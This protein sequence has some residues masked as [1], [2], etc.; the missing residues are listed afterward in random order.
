MNP[1][2]CLSRVNCTNQFVEG[3]FR[4]INEFQLI[5]E[6]EMVELAVHY[7]SGPSGLKALRHHHQG[8]PTSQKRDKRLLVPPTE[9]HTQPASLVS[10]LPEATQA[11][12]A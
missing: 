6:E 7:L 5:N 4:F 12:V 10:V 8:L 9:G 2:P 3:K 1:F 11:W